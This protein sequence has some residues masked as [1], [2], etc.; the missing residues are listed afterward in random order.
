MVITVPRSN[1]HRPFSYRLKHRRWYNSSMPTDSFPQSPMKD[2]KL[3]IA[4]SVVWGLAAVLLIAL[5]V[6]SYSTND[7]LLIRTG[8]AQHSNV[9]LLSNWGFLQAL[10]NQTITIPKGIGYFNQPAWERTDVGFEWRQD[11]AIKVPDIFSSLS[12]SL[13]PFALG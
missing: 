3:R 8:S 5:W 7:H 11:G 1:G 2:R 6:R 9:V 10:F 4:W 13:V 12:P